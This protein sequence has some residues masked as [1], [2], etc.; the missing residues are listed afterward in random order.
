MTDAAHGQGELVESTGELLA[1]VAQVLGRKLVDWRS[2][3]SEPTA[4][5]VVSGYQ[6]DLQDDR[7][8]VRSQTLYIETN[9]PQRTRSG[10]LTLRRAGSNDAVDVWFYP[11]DPGLPGLARVVRPES[12]EALLASIGVDASDT[13]LAVAAY[14]PGS[15]A[16]VRVDWSGGRVYLK[17]VSP[18][19]AAALADRHRLLAASGIPVPEV[20][21]WSDDGLVA[22]ATLPGVEAQSVVH[23]LPDPDGFLD[24]VEEIAARLARVPAIYTVRSSLFDRL[25][26]YVGRLAASFPA[27]ARDIEQI[28]HLAQRRGSS[29]RDFFQGPVTIHGD[30]HLG[31]IFVQDGG[32]RRVTGVL[33]VDTAGAGDLADDAAALYAHLIVLGINAEGSGAGYAEACLSLADLWLERWQLHH[34]SGYADRT[35]AIAAT[36]LIA[37]SLR[38]PEGDGER[39]AARVLDLA[40]RLVD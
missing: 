22:L 28:G 26:W 2:T 11:Q 37:H 35:R 1:S 17:V 8:G 9:P 24:Q 36:H 14:R 18:R 30:L 6:I 27:L 39:S 10:V 29:G 15:R 32:Q 3:H 20:L 5:G 19:K 31:Q 23:L 38:Y 34:D 25:D 40:R 4:S 33:D 12:A 21:G 13:S 16:V 7:G